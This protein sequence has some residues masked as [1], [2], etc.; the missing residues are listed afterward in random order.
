MSNKISRVCFI[1]PHGH[2]KFPAPLGSTDTGG[3]TIYEFQLAKTLGK[4]GIKVDI[5]TRQF[6]NQPTEEEVFENVH[7][8]RIPCGG[9]DFIRKEKMFELM[10][11]FVDN[12]VDYIRK[13]NKKYNI[14]HTHYWDAGYAG[15]LLKKILKV[16]H[17]HSPHSLGKLK[18]IEMAVEDLPVS[19]LKP[20]YRYHV[21]IAIEQRIYNQADVVVVLCET[22][23]IQLLQH[24]IVDFEKIKIIFPGIE[25]EFFNLKATERDK[26]IHLKQNSILTMCRLVPTKGIDRVIDALNIIKRKIDFHLY[27]GGGSDTDTIS[28]EE[29]EN[30]LRIKEMIKRYNIQDRVTFLGY[31]DHDRVLPAYYRKADLFILPSRFEPF[32]LTTLEAMACGTLPI[33]S[34]T[35]GSKEIIIDGLNG[36][37]VNTHDRKE[38]ANTILKILADNKLRKKVSEN[39][40]FTISEHYSWDKIV[41][42]FISLYNELL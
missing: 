17:V 41:N 42:K 39:A 40:A 27:V 36:F 21:R 32:G 37:I 34:H 38:L 13:K 2:V 25:T 19:K 9:T 26:K 31:I 35:A 16:P 7:I 29:Q 15:I 11:E 20:A 8:V 23:R 33:V 14:I 5:I 28:G 1:N 22:N 24:Y 6:E 18:K 12:F 30:V 4:R 3:Q 10:P